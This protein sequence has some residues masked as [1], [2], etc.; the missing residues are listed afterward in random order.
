MILSFLIENHIDSIFPFSTLITSLA[1]LSLPALL[2]LKVQ[3]WSSGRRWWL[4]KK[5]PHLHSIPNSFNLR[6]QVEHRSLFTSF[7]SSTGSSYS[8]TSLAL[9]G[10]LLDFSSFFGVI[11]VWCLDQLQLT[12]YSTESTS[13]R[14][15]LNRKSACSWRRAGRQLPHSGV[16]SLQYSCDSII[17]NAILS[18]LYISLKK[19]RTSSRSGDVLTLTLKRR[20][21]NPQKGSWMGRVCKKT[22]ATGFEPVR[23]TP[24]DFESVSLTT[25]TYW[26]PCLSPPSPLFILK[27]CTH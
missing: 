5:R 15:P 26:Q 16:S 22:S 14:S 1:S 12:S 4:Q 17:T 13:S 6:L 11:G 18:Q 20:H 21:L 3:L 9:S 7:F 10:I 19:R 27:I 25:R 23:V 2:W 24:T 8:F